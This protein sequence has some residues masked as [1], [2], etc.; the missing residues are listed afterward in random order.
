MAIG[1]GRDLIDQMDL[2]TQVISSWIIDK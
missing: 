2:D 1:E